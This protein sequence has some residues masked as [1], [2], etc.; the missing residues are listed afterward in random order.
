MF[1][2]KFLMAQEQIPQPITSTAWKAI[3]ISWLVLALTRTVFL[4]HGHAY[5]TK[6]MEQSTQ[7]VLSSTTG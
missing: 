7:R 3:W 5:F 2:E 6:V 1:Q 4:F